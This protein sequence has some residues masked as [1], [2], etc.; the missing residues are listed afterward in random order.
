MVKGTETLCSGVI[1]CPRG[2]S[3]VKP[4]WLHD[5]QPIRAH[6]LWTP[7]TRSLKTVDSSSA[8]QK[9][10]VRFAEV[11]FVLRLSIGCCSNFQEG[12]ATNAFWLSWINVEDNI[13]RGES[14]GA[15]NQL[16]GESIG[17]STPSHWQS[18]SIHRTVKGCD[19]NN[20]ANTFGSCCQVSSSPPSIRS[21]SHTR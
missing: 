16:D 17:F 13:N 21:S 6:S 7:T 19:L 1:N 18:A 3:G 10:K 20:K 2:G 4:Y 9:F 15:G 12:T 5:D 11:A 8:C 14:T